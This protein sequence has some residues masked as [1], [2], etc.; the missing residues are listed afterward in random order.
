VDGLTLAW[1][2]PQR[3]M[4]RKITINGQAEV[5]SMVGNIAIFQGKTLLHTH[6]VVGLSDGTARGGH[7]LDARVSPTLEVMVTVDPIEM[8]RRIDPGTGLPLIDPALSRVPVS[9]DYKATMNT[10]D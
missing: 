2:D 9:G 1:F 4:Y 7:V 10:G 8:Q 6:M 5:L 3:K